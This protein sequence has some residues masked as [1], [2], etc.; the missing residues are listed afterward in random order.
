M[1]IGLTVIGIA[2]AFG[3]SPRAT[4]DR[5]NLVLGPVVVILLGVSCH[6]LYRFRRACIEWK[7]GQQAEAGDETNGGA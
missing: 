2:I 3:N 5:L 7:Q 1:V 6:T 4:I